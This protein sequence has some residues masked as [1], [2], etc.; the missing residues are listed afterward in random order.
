M[1]FA[2]VS[3]LAE[4]LSLAYDLTLVIATMAVGST[5][6]AGGLWLLGRQ[7]PSRGVAALLLAVALSLLAIVSVSSILPFSE[8]QMAAATPGA[9]AFR[10]VTVVFLSELGVTLVL[11][12]AGAGVDLAGT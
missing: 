3:G 8:W 5:L 11:G 6:S 7:R 9:I 12:L 4:P 10:P 2:S 1:V